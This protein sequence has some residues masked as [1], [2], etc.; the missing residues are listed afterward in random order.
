MTRVGLA[1]LILLVGI[2]TGH[3][4]AASGSIQVSAQVEG[5]GEMLSGVLEFRQEVGQTDVFRFRSDRGVSCT[6]SLHQ[7][8]GVLSEAVLQCADGRLGI[9]R[10]RQYGKHI[11]SEASL[12]DRKLILTI[13]DAASHRTR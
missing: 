8:A 2:A 10:L 6:G 1:V 7:K 11:V 9:I 3:P 5:T 13:P 12:G 4:A